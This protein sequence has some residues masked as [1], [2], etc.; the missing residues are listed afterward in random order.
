MGH[1]GNMGHGGSMGY[2]SQCGESEHHRHG[3]GK[4]KYDKDD[5]EKGHHKHR[6][7]HYSG[8]CGSNV[9]TPSA[10]ILFTDFQYYNLG[11]P[12]NTEFPFK[13]LS[14]SGG[15]CV[16]IIFPGSSGDSDNCPPSSG[17]NNSALRKI[18]LGLGGVLNIASENGRFKVPTLRNVELTAPYMH[19]G[20]LKTL[21][22]VVRFYNLRDSG[23]WGLPEVGE[24]VEQRR[25]GN[26]GLSSAQ[27]DA[28]VAFLLTLTDGHVVDNDGGY[29]QKYGDKKHKYD[30]DDYKKHAK[31][32]FKKHAKK[33]FKNRSREYSKKYAKR[34]AE[35]YAD[36]Y[37][38]EYANRYS[39]GY[40]NKY[41][42]K[43]A[44][45][46]AKKYGKKYAKRYAKKRDD[47]D[48]DYEKYSK[49]HKHDDDYEKYSKKYKHDDDDDYEK[50]SKKYKHDD[51]DDYEKYSKKYKHDDD[52]DYEKYSKK[53]KHD[54]DDDYEKYSKKHKHDDD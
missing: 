17:F 30:D 44:K 32:Y 19:N 6:H 28:I 3:H 10:P 36:R 41:A 39:E 45:K 46:Y 38:E 11:L 20:V 4:H 22:E 9:P 35:E 42:E 15:S 52:D 5:H 29:G 54:D 24:N 18:D 1:S 31:K 26:L 27:E 40:V 48:D 43:Y 12:R 7:G 53:Y 50:Y 33:Y 16:I 34:Y 47:D 37:S 49:K 25:M 21:K 14:S 23:E 51:D 13:D 8:G 2:G